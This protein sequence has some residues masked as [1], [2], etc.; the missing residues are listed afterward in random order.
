MLTIL[1]VKLL[2]F[3]LLVT[4]LAYSETLIKGDVWLIVTK[5]DLSL[6]K[7]ITLNHDSNSSSVWSVKHSALSLTSKK[8]KHL[9]MQKC[10][11]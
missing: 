10:V 6:K 1:K 5:M 2:T 11:L 4:N 8:Q 7:S 3:D 9:T